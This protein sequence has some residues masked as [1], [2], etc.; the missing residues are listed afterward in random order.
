M[1]RILF[2]LLLMLGVGI[3]Q[4]QQ[5]HQR[6]RSKLSI[7]DLSTQKVHVIYTMDAIFEAPTGRLTAGPSFSI[8]VG[9]Y[10]PFR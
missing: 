2:L 9:S 6:L 10:L 8:R 4:A 7:Y 3:L 5:S 1:L